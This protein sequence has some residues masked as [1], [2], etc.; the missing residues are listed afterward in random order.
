MKVLLNNK[1]KKPLIDYERDDN[2]K[3]WVKEN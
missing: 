3:D 1:G 2:Y